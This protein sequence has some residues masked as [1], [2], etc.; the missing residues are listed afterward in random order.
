MASKVKVKKT[1]LERFRKL[2]RESK[3][4]I[5]AY[6]LGNIVSPN[7]VVVTDFVYPK[8]YK[9]QTKTGVCWTG[10]EFSAL[11]M[12]ADFEGKNIVGDI[13]SHPNW[14]P[15]KSEP[16]H[17]A[18]IADQLRVCGIC[19]VYGKKTYVRFWLAES[20]L[21]MEIIYK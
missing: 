18:Q 19:S 15:I 17:T 21:P 1:A 16:D 20:S 6:L 12:R 5:Q 2:A 8:E 4:E 11:K 14:F 10:E 3:V 7:L 9:A 13:H